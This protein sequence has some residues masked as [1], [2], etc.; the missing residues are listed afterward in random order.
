MLAVAIGLV[1]VGVPPLLLPRDRNPSPSAAPAAVAPPV[2]AAGASPSAVGNS[3]GSAAQSQ[4]ASPVAPAASPCGTAGSA[5]PACTV[6]GAAVGTGWS[7]RSV[8]VKVVTDGVVPGTDQVALRVEPKEKTAAV[9]LVAAT[10]VAATRLTFRVYGG[11]VHG[12]VLRVTVSATPDPAGTPPLVL[13]APVDVWTP[14]D[15]DLRELAPGRPVRR[16]DLVVATDML[17]N[18]YRFFVDDLQLR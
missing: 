2:P 15:V 14:F 5:R 8:G 13:T 9:A 3:G 6:Y 4:P 12:T 11:R 10:P 16:I 18:A 7:V 17:P 1:T